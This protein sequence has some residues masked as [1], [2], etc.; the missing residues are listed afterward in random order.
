MRARLLWRLWRALGRCYECGR[1]QRLPG[2]STLCR[3]CYDE[4]VRQAM[5]FFLITRKQP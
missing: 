3:R 5:G 4:H 1:P 2:Q